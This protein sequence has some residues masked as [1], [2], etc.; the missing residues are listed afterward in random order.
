MEVLLGESTDKK[1][2]I[3]L[4]TYIGGQQERPEDIVTAMANLEAHLAFMENFDSDENADK[5]L[6]VQ[7]LRQLADVIT[8]Q[9]FMKFVDKYQSKYPWIP[10]TLLVNVQMIFAEFATIARNNKFILKVLR[11]EVI[12]KS[13]FDRVRSLFKDCLSD[14]NKAANMQ[15]FVLFQTAPSSYASK[16]RPN[17]SD[18]QSSSPRDGDPALR[19]KKRLRGDTSRGWFTASGPIKFP[20]SLTERLCNRFGQVGS[21]C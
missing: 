2:K 10:H 5:P 20:S 8:S 1:A 4:E 3:G 18:G 16:K 12:P 9:K 15:S 21:V 7:M 11:K 17:P 19:D 6:I 14:F 13:A